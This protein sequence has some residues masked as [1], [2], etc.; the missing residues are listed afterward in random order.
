MKILN[1]KYRYF[2]RKVTDVTHS[3][4]ELEFKIAK[5]RQ[6]REGIRQDR[7]RAVES[8]HQITEALKTAKK[9]DKEK[10]EADKVAHEENTKRYEAQMKMIDDEINGGTPTE[11]NP[12]GIG[13]MERLKSYAELRNM[14]VEYAKSV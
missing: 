2:R 3:M 7:D 12:S 4:W 8:V 13:I 1:S 11:G 5:S 14:Y 6:V 9:E 10:Y